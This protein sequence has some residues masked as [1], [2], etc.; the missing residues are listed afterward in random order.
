VTIALALE[1]PRAVPSIPA[2]PADPG[3]APNPVALRLGYAGLLPFVLGALL[4]WLVQPRPEEHAFVVDALAK[5]AALVVAFLGGI[6]WGL[7]F[8]QTVPSPS[9]FAWGAVP[10]LL[11]WVAVVMPPCAG[12]ALQGAA[13]IS[14]YL[15]DRRIYPAHGLAAWLTLRFRL[16]AVASL[17]CFIAA[18]AS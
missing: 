7:E 12:L 8:R 6:H 1:P 10:V 4:A 18:A 3:L 16:S 17:S 14:C 2:R 11:A 15:V 5:Y 13:L 9:R